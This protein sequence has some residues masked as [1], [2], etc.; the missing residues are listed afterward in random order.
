M[1]N[2]ANLTFKGYFRCK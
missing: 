1:S 2:G